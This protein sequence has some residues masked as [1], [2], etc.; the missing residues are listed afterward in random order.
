M[1]LFG[2][3]SGAY[4]HDLSLAACGFFGIPSTVAIFV[5]WA[6]FVG[7]G[8]GRVIFTQ[9]AKGPNLCPFVY[10]STRGLKTGQ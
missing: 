6:V 5:R 10:S 4:V 3:A 7:S 8:V 2:H 1:P 9:D